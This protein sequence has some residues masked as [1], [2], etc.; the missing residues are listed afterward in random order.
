MPGPAKLMSSG[1]VPEARAIAQRTWGRDACRM[2][3]YAMHEAVM[4]VRDLE[5]AESAV[6]QN[7]VKAFA[8]NKAKKKLTG[9]LA[10]RR[11]GAGGDKERPGT[12]ERPALG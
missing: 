1:S 12:R 2:D 8:A 11:G 9:L 7:A 6:R 3:A 4:A 10:S 5:E